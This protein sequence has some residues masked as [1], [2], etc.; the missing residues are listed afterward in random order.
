[1]VLN[2]E[3]LEEKEKE[4][5]LFYK[6]S[7][8]EDDTHKA[9]SFTCENVKKYSVAN[10]EK[11][12]PEIDLVYA[13]D[14]QDIGTNP[15][16]L[17]KREI[18]QKDNMNTVARKILFENDSCA[19][20]YQINDHVLG[21]PLP[22][23][24]DDISIDRKKLL[25][26]F[27]PNSKF[28]LK[29]S[30]DMIID[31]TDDVK[32][33]SKGLN[34]L[35]D[36][37]LRKHV[38]TKKQTDNMSEVTAIHLQDT[39]NDSVPVEELPFKLPTSTDNSELNKPGAKLMRLK[40]HLK[41]QMSLK[42]NEEWKQKEIELQMQK[43]EDEEDE[44][45][46]NLDKQEEAD[47]LESSDSG[48][49]E[50][51]ENDVCIKDKKKKKCLFADDEA[52]VT[53]NE[54][55][56]AY[57]TDTDEA[58][59][60]KQS[61]SF[62]YGNEKNNTDDSESDMEEAEDTDE[63]KNE[64][65]FKS[66]TEFMDKDKA[67]VVIDKSKNINVAINEKRRKRLIQRY[68]DDSENEDSQLKSIVEIHTSKVA[69]EDGGWT[70]ENE[71][72]MQQ[73]SKITTKSQ[74]CKTPL[75]IVKT[76]MLDFVSPITQLSILNTSFDSDTKEMPKNMQSDQSPHCAHKIRNKSISQKKLFY[77]VEENV[78][79]EYLMQLCSTKFESTQKSDFD[80]KD[81]TS[82]FDTTESQLREFDI[83]N[84]DAKLNDV[85]ELKSLE[86]ETKIS[87]KIDLFNTHSSVY[88]TK[89]LEVGTT[90]SELKSKIVP[91]IVPDDEEELDEEDTFLRP[92]K[93]LTKRLDL[94]D[95]E[96][97]DAGFSNKE[98]DSANNEETEEKYI[99]Y[100][101]EENEVIVVPKKDV[102][103][104]AADFLEEEAELSES[105]WDSADEDEKD[106]DKLDFEEA[107]EEHIDE[108]KMKDQLGKIHM[109]QMLDEDK[110]NV[111]LLKEL[112]FEDGD[113][114]TDGTGRERKFKWRNIGMIYIRVYIIHTYIYR[115]I[116][117]K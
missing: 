86:A 59:H 47:I 111:R 66:E 110:R 51:E 94:S 16:S 12:V 82:Q 100:D 99:D 35:L 58:E 88:H 108:D 36:R 92:K 22:K 61:T 67:N 33:N 77:D 112:L 21:L 20:D 9:K 80:V 55:S 76:T 84:S 32:P 25:S 70:S 41:L 18:M 87:Q 19:A 44:T 63:D 49:S 97:E 46:Y 14:M 116:H 64:N 37:F 13:Q 23:F 113:L 107:D 71:S 54:N 43:K 106:L 73:R 29:G 27:A 62:K 81:L 114:H 95:S 90:G 89:K 6:S 72:N 26:K 103:K 4:A 117:R 15:D 5:E 24:T 68:Q 52:D 75:P 91:S 101:S 56:D 96:D 57:E 1:M 98:N 40:E 39:E 78:D 60:S 48:E 11:L 45:D 102:R 2:S 10:E 3:I 109:K 53:D 30:P 65:E 115:I 31:L 38:N 83:E 34:N 74:I 79:D 7:D 93:R 104:V 28:T 85:K 50:P 105:D 42:R 69:S 8:S 17:S